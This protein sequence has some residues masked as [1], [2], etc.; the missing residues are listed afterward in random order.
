M[1]GIDRGVVVRIER[2]QPT[3]YRRMTGRG[4][5]STTRLAIPSGSD[6]AC[7][8]GPDYGSSLGEALVSEGL[9]GVFA[10]EVCGGLPEP[11]ERLDVSD[12]R[13]LVAMAES[14]WSR[15]DY[16]HDAWFFGAADLPRWLGYSLGFQ[17][18]KRFL[19]EHEGSTSSR[20]VEMEAEAFRGMLAVI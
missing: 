10:Q 5:V 12:I 19:L 16:G 9:A 4:T 1:T 13:R 11:W 14:D 7:W 15:N 20:L 18:V 8:D 3:I 17:L 6:A 2:S